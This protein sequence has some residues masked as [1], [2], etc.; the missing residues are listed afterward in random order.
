MVAARKAQQVHRVRRV[1]KVQQVRTEQMEQTG[2]KVHRVPLDRLD[3]QAR[4]EQ[5]GSKVPLDPQG[6]LVQR[7]IKESADPLVHRVLLALVLAAA[8]LRYGGNLRLL[9]LRTALELPL[10]QTIQSCGFW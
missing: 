2:S 9:V 1:S 7:E 8:L 10:L 4:T 6:L 3:P 5:T